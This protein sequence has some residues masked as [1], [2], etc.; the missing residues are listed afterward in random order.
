MASENKLSIHLNDTINAT[1]KIFKISNNIIELRESCFETLSVALSSCL[2]DKT[3]L[4]KLKALMCFRELLKICVPISGCTDIDTVKNIT[5]KFINNPFLSIHDQA[6]KVLAILLI[7][8]SRLD[9]KDSNFSSEENREMQSNDNS[10]K[11]CIFYLKYI[12]DFHAKH[13]TNPHI[14]R[15]IISIYSEFLEHCEREWILNHYKFIIKNHICDIASV[16]NNIKDKQKILTTRNIICRFLSII[17]KKLDEE[18][19]F[20]ALKILN[21]ECLNIWL[22]KLGFTQAKKVVLTSILCEISKFILTLS[23]IINT[24]RESLRD[25]LLFILNCTSLTIQKYTSWCIK[26]LAITIPK[27][28]TYLVIFCLK[29]IKEFISTDINNIDYPSKLRIRGYALTL[30]RLISIGKQNPL[31]I[32]SDIFSEIFL[33]SCSILKLTTNNAI[34]T[35]LIHVQIAWTLI[36]SLMKLGSS[37]VRNYLSGLF[38]LWENTLLNPSI[39]N[40]PPD[41]NQLETLFLL[42]TREYALGSIFS[43]LLHNKELLTI[44]VLKK[45]SFILNETNT[46]L[47]LLSKRQKNGVFLDDYV[48]LSQE[49]LE[50]MIHKKILQCYLLIIWKNPEDS[51]QNELISRLITNFASPYVTIVKNTLNYQSY[52]YSY[53]SQNI[54]GV[55][56]FIYLQGFSNYQEIYEINNII[57]Q[58]Y[59]YVPKD[60]ALINIINN[61]DFNSQKNNSLQV[62]DILSS[63]DEIPWNHL[64][65]YIE[66][67]DLSILLFGIIFL[68]QSNK[69]KESILEQLITFITLSS[70]IK[71]FQQKIAHGINSQNPA[72]RRISCETIGRLTCLQKKQLL[73]S[74]K[75]YI[76][77]IIEP[78]NSDIRS[79]S[80]LCLDVLQSL[81]I[82]QNSEVCFW[83]LESIAIGIQSFGPD[84]SSYCLNILN[85]ISKIYN[86]MDYNTNNT[87]ITISNLSLRFPILCNLTKCLNAIVNIFGPDLQKNTEA[88]KLVSVLIR[89]L[90][91][92]NN[93]EVLAE[94]IYCAQH[95]LLF[96]SDLL[97]PYL[98]VK[99]LQTNIMSKNKNLARTSVKSLYQLMQNDTL[100]VFKWGESNLDACIWLAYDSNPEIEELK[101]IIEIWLYHT[102]DSLQN[103]WIHLC[104]KTFEK[105]SCNKIVQEVN[106]NI[107]RSLKNE[108]SCIFKI[109]ENYNSDNIEEKLKRLRW[110][111]QKLIL[112]CINNLL[113]SIEVYFKKCSSL[114]ISQKISS[115]SSNISNLIKIGFMASTGKNYDIRFEGLKIIQKIIKIFSPFKDPDF[116]TLSLL[117]QYEAQLVSAIIPSFSSDSIPE[118]AVFAMHICSYFLTSEILKEIPKTG[119]IIK[120]LS[121]ALLDINNSEDTISIGD[122]ECSNNSRILLKLSIISVWAELQIASE[123]KTCL[124]FIIKPNLSLLIPLWI[125]SLRDYT[126]FFFGTCELSNNLSYLTSQ[127]INFNKIFSNI[128]NDELFEICNKFWINV[129][130]AISILLESNKN[131]I[132]KSITWY[133]LNNSDNM[134]LD[135]K[136]NHKKKTSILFFLLFG[137]CFEALLR[138]ISNKR[139]INTDKQKLYILSALEKILNISLHNEIIYSDATFSEL[140]T[141]L[142]RLLLTEHP[143]IQILI[144]R[145]ATSL[146]NNYPQKNQKRFKNNKNY[147][148]QQKNVP[149]YPNKLRQ[150]SEIII[151]PL[152][153]YFQHNTIINDLKAHEH[154]SNLIIYSLESYIKIIKKFPLII[155]YDFYNCTF[156]IILKLYYNE[157]SYHLIP[158]ILPLVKILCEDILITSRI[159]QKSYQILQNL[160]ENILNQL[161]K[162]IQDLPKAWEYGLPLA[163]VIM[164]ITGQILSPKSKSFQKYYNLFTKSLTN[165]EA[166]ILIHCMKSLLTSFSYTKRYIL[167]SILFASFNI[168]KKAH[169]DF[170][171]S[172][173]FDIGTNAYNI[174]ID[175]IKNISENN[176]QYIAIVTIMPILIRFVSNE[177]LKSSHK[178]EISFKLLSLMACFELEEKFGNYISKKNQEIYLLIKDNYFNIMSISDSI[179]KIEEDL[180]TINEQFIKIKSSFGTEKLFK[181]SINL[182][183]RF[184]IPVYDDKLIYVYTTKLLLCIPQLIRKLAS[185][186]EYLLAATLLYKINALNDELKIKRK[187]NLLSDIPILESKAFLIKMIKKKICDIIPEKNTYIILSDLF[188]LNIILEKTSLG[189]EKMFWKI[190]LKDISDISYKVIMDPNNFYFLLKKIL[191]T[192][193]IGQSI[194]PKEFKSYIKTRL[195]IDS[196]LISKFRHI[197][198]ESM[199]ILQHYKL[200][201]SS[202]E[203]DKLTQ[204]NSN[205]IYIKWEN[206]I[207]KIIQHNGSNYLNE[208]KTIKSLVEQWNNI[209]LFFEQTIISF[210]EKNTKLNTFISKLWKSIEII[211]NRRINSMLK[212]SIN[213]L[214]ELEEHID[215]ELKNIKM[216]NEPFKSS[217]FKNNSEIWDDNIKLTINSR[218][219]KP[220]I[221]IENFKNKLNKIQKKLE[222]DS[223]T[224]SKRRKPINI[225]LEN[226]KSDTYKEN[227]VSNFHLK[228]IKNM[229]NK[230]S[231]NI[232][233]TISVFLTLN[234][235]NNI[236]NTDINIICYFIRIIKLVKFSYPLGVDLNFFCNCHLKKLYKTLSL[237]I[238]LHEDIKRKLETEINRLISD[239]KLNILWKNNQISLPNH[240]SSQL[241]TII[242]DLGWYMTNI[243][244]DIFDYD[245]MLIIHYCFIDII[246][247]ILKNTFNPKSFNE[248]KNYKKNEESKHENNYLYCNVENFEHIHITITGQLQLYFDMK[249]L[250][251]LFGN[252]PNKNKKLKKLNYIINH[253]TKNVSKNHDL[254]N[255]LILNYIEK[256]KIWFDFL[257]IH[258]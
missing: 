144:I 210:N 230:L 142:K 11:K 216:Q 61:L 15:F 5:T 114:Q 166:K 164:T 223:S 22:D 183:V 186:S 248:N 105:K 250:L 149:N 256:T 94:A 96:S 212:F 79:S 44:N 174:I 74:I 257:I 117:E 231:K 226:L 87:S 25:N 154:M 253:N 98:F 151:L 185:N 249:Y 110:Q 189:I 193:I 191:Y 237:Y 207:L 9:S 170:K 176:Q 31:Y 179:I 116:P 196:L 162:I 221:F 217:L 218:I 234:P 39:S 167:Q 121:S 139:V 49:M 81:S 17:R 148:D 34:H 150:L 138:S 99:L 135:K 30:S 8:N 123:R 225:I 137:I 16:I 125:T 161:T 21:E 206:E 100:S 104:L 107:N 141:L 171:K 3:D 52:Y 160:I 82:D 85:I 91:L 20:E 77:E 244:I 58:N 219:H 111:T 195:E 211:F 41:A 203:L 55:S 88:K 51:T 168:I 173:M 208:I 213:I 220:T 236:S 37:F 222:K 65:I 136:T 26:C 101:N 90:L 233:K 71:P 14:E 42:Y 199:H 102:S 84:K 127:S 192:A 224:I 197:Y 113:L 140:V 240:P 13:I 227:N 23:N 75:F 73:P 12:S 131:I 38:L 194:F 188:S 68:N 40:L 115:L 128:N 118:I 215:N 48:Q 103:Y 146:V 200:E 120:L 182:N 63:F 93:E 232:G 53:S 133:E 177:Q 209:L 62:Y 143:I 4:I 89:G 145:I 109:D 59:I 67:I 7:T 204:D 27:D 119:R 36:S 47:T 157:N 106:K 242:Q 147:S 245:A 255:K 198:N 18:S 83:A 178:K 57:L 72:I 80:A 95:I 28:I 46:V 156:F 169:L 129:V 158:K 56:S 180:K 254:I 32:S 190:R 239:K 201:E 86:R 33:I 126:K 238:F 258:N 29:H 1:F 97:N 163:T 228:L 19:Q 243:G 205:N 252:I 6:A 78:N 214:L 24:I 54:D 43:F 124:S 66:I 251:A 76:R 247:S 108:E 235:N 132:F 202:F 60:Y 122:L 130:Y 134:K 69:I 152:I 246:Y 70:N 50:D 35:I 165:D 2:S 159:N 184:K 92:E 187:D 155:Q 181:S 153:L 229:Y 172:A 241:I 10:K 64:P 45:I 112:Q 175:L